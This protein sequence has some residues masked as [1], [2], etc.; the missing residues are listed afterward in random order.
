MYSIYVR[1]F[2]LQLHLQNNMPRKNSDLINEQLQLNLSSILYIYIYI[3][4]ANSAE[5]G[6]PFLVPHTHESNQSKCEGKG[7][8]YHYLWR[9]WELFV[10]L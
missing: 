2:F 8:G 4:I 10:S 1:F 9:G 7:K 3:Y 5:I 6:Q